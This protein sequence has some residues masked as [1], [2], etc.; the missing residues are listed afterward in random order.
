M[1]RDS[2]APKLECAAP[3]ALPDEKPRAKQLRV[4]SVSVATAD[5]ATR[6][7][8]SDSAIAARLRVL[9]TETQLTQE[10]AAALGAVWPR[11]VGRYERAEVDLSQA[12]YVLRLVE[13]RE[14]QKGG[15]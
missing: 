12:R 10:D 8:L 15:R 9:R 5:D 13:F 2:S 14:R 11:S 3:L 4:S 6:T 7:A 1:G